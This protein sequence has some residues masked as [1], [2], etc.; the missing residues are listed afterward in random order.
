MTKALTWFVGLYVG[1]LVLIA[2]VWSLADV[3]NIFVH[4]TEQVFVHLIDFTIFMVAGVA[5]RSFLGEAVLDFWQNL[6]SFV[7]E[8]REA[9]KRF[10][11]VCRRLYSGGRWLAKT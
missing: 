2:F 1:I 5:V 10:I 4:R 3:S 8:R 7:A 6:C 11:E 9:I